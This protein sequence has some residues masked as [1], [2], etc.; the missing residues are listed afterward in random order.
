MSSAA[1]SYTVHLGFWT[2]W[3]QGK[4]QG[5]TVTLTRD[6]GAFLIAFL[7]IFVGMAGKSFWRLG[8]FCLHRYFSS[9]DREDGLYHQRQAIL[10]NS[11]TAQDGAWRMFMSLLAWRS[12]QRASRPFMRLLPL[13]FFALFTAAAF[14]IASIFSSRVTTDTLNE[15]L[16]TGEKCGAIDPYK[17]NDT[18]KILTLIMPHNAKLSSSSLNYGLQCYTN[19]TN[20]DGCNLYIKPQLPLKSNRGIACPFG[21][22]IC[23]LPNDNLMMDTGYLDSLE[24]FGLNTAP[25]ERF[26][27]RLTHTCAVIKTEGYTET[28]NDTQFGPIVRY[29]YGGMVYNDGALGDGD[30]NGTRWTYEIPINNS[31]IPTDGSHSGETSRYEYTVGIESHYGTPD[32]SLLP[33]GYNK[34]RPITALLREDADVEAVFLAA[35]NIRFAQQVDDPFFSAHKVADD[36]VDLDTGESLNSYLQDE[37][38]RTLACAN[39]MQYCNPNLP[40]GQRCEPLRG[41]NDPR[42]SAELK[43]IFG[44]GKHFDILKYADSAWTSAYMSMH[45]LLGFVGASAIKAR[46]GLS[47]GYQG[48]LPDNQWQLEAEFW[49]KGTLASIQDAFATAA[50][51]PPEEMYEFLDQPLKN[52]TTPWNLCKNQKIV[53]TKFSS[54]NVLG[55]SLILLLGIWII[56]LD[57]GLE[58]TVA[59]WQR[60]QYKKHQLRD[61]YYAESKEGHPLYAA[62]EWSHTSTLQLQ[63]LAHEEAGFGTWSACDGDTPVTLPGQRLA[64]L[65]LTDVKHPELKRLKE[66]PKEWDA[67]IASKPWGLRRNDTGMDTLVEESV[68]DKKEQGVDDEI[69]GVMG[70][71]SPISAAR[72]LGL[73]A[74]GVGPR[75]S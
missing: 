58:P 21:D 67:I 47:Y 3:S 63:R 51:G 66:S 75:R 28:F 46:Y 70:M 18:S 57:M 61:E 33:F 38:M 44:E 27:L 30:M 25:D 24:H 69:D 6:R 73:P 41:I 48:P 56:V 29:L 7:A 15:V 9:H 37:P 5:A 1:S 52:D 40:V 68:S 31:Y 35:P 39:Q 14:G 34:W 23:V 11:D 50:N 59:W 2:N 74:P 36:I 4:I 65:N 45:H 43:K 20:T 13:I 16:L 64:S 22:D 71:M 54:F 12:G 26:Q 62:L 19:S 8:C 32:E 10:R 49:I 42:R 72:S 55:I 17:P 53:S 60:R